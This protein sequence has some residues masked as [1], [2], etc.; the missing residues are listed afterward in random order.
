ME[1]TKRIKHS[2]VYWID[3]CKISDHSIQ[4]VFRVGH[5]MYFT[6]VGGILNKVNIDKYMSFRFVADIKS[7][8]NIIQ[9][10]L[11]NSN[12]IP[13]SSKSVH[14]DELI[15]TNETTGPIQFKRKAQ[16]ICNVLKNDNILIK[17][18]WIKF[19]DIN[20]IKML[21]SH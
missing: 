9:I 12:I 14:F 11:Q 1:E 4:Y 8:R 2:S 18:K 3:S 15:L 10:I 21:K 7:K 19:N 13:T 17:G 5:P 6:S 20:I 16:L